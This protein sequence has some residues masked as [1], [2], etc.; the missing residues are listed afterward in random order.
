VSTKVALITGSSRGIGRTIALRLARAGFAIVVNY[1]DE[2]EA[3]RAAEVVTAAEQ[4]G[5][6]AIAVEA[7]V[8]CVDRIRFLFEKARELGPGPDVVVS[9]AAGD[10]VV[11][12]LVETTEA[13]FDDAIALNAR[14]QFFVLQEAARHVPDGGRVI[15]LSTSS[16]ST[17]Y[18]GM[19]SY[20]GAKRAAEI[21][22]LVLAS[23]LGPRGI[24]VNVVAPG[25][26]DT[27]QFRLQNSEDRIQYLQGITPL[28]R[29]G[30]P[31]DIADVVC[32]LAS[33]RARWI[34]RQVI[35][36]SGGIS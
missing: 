1:P 30:R 35:Q 5:G 28:R 4:A 8:R 21:Y 26:T 31:E 24:T 32:F 13:E 22:A 6:R 29:L 34:T 18:P 12:S 10:A 14:S 25:P 9:N 33:D 20:A 15:V 7:D 36:V 27:E 3:A 2:S 16:V 17:P 19:A 11:R 23:E